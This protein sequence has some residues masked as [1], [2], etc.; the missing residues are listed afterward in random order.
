MRWVVG[1]LV[2]VSSTLAAEPHYA[3]R[4]LIPGTATTENVRSLLGPPT[5]ALGDDELWYDRA[6]PKGSSDRLFFSGGKLRGVAAA[7]PDPRYPDRERIVRAFGP[8]EMDIHFRTQEVLD[9]GEKGLRFV[10][11]AQGKT[12]GILYLTPGRR[13]VPEGYPN[14]IDLRRPTPAVPGK[15]PTNLRC[16]AARVSIAPLRFEGLLAKPAPGLHLAQDVVATALVFERAGTRIA[17]V[18]LDVFGLFSA[19]IARLRQALAKR[20]LSN[21]LVCMSHTHANVDTIG[22]Y[23]Y[24]P[25]EYVDHIVQQTEAA[26]IGAMERLAP[27]AEWKVGSVE[28]PLAGGRVSELVL[29]WRDPGILDPTV[30]VLEVVGQNEK[31]IGRVVHLACHPE[32][33]QLEQTKGISPDFVGALRDELNRQ[34]GGETIFLNGALGGMV[35]PDC[36]ARTQAEAERVGRGLAAHCLQASRSARPCANDRL[37]FQ[38]RPVEVP[39]TSDRIRQF[40][41]HAPGPVNQKEGRVRTEMN[42]VWLGDLQMITVPGELLPEPGMQITAALLGEGRIVVG[43]TN[44]ELGYLIPSYD[45]RAGQYEER[46]GPGA[47]GGD[48][49]RDVGLELAPQRPIGSP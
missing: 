45:F 8:A 33:I 39:I 47:A 42:L 28:M 18:G 32:V 48:I 49:V 6:Q 11:D 40:L 12:M 2:L 13:R 25:K 10:L 1:Q 27:V 7:S 15:S 19:D 24:Y 16:G 38:R 35:S 41:D 43:L 4:G 36:R 20:G 31:P 46:T 37:F 29:N 17:I 3:Y 26:V 21:V 23:G 14:Q 30:T 5:H 9:Y 44:D 22:F 34:L